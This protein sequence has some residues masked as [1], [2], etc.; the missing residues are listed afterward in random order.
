MGWLNIHERFVFNKNQSG[1]I[2]RI[3]WFDIIIRNIYLIN[4]KIQKFKI[5]KDK[6]RSNEI[7]L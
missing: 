3:K 4:I 2:L 1:I 6:Y 5:T 7:T